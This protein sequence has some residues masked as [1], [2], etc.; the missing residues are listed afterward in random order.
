MMTATMVRQLPLIEAQ[1]VWE[2]I[3]DLP[4]R[5][6]EKNRCESAEA[7]LESVK[8]DAKVLVYKNDLLLGFVTLEEKADGTFEVH[9]FCPRKVTTE[10]LT[11][12]IDAFFDK[13]RSDRRIETLIFNVRSRQNR[14]GQILME[15]GCIYTGWSYREN[16]ENFRS[17]FWKKQ[18]S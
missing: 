15:N 16:G 9:L 18:L 5:V 3:K 4:S 1:T 11:K 12:A 7:F 2:W 14:L 13:V 10:D 17:L 8:N 6:A